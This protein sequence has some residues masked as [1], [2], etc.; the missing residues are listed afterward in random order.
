MPNGT[1]YVM[2][3]LASN[4]IT[5]PDAPI[6][7]NLGNTALPYEPYQGS[8]TQLPLPKTCYGGKVE[9]RHN[10]EF[11]KCIVLDGTEIWTEYTDE[12]WQGAGYHVYRFYAADALLV[13]PIVSNKYP[14]V[15]GLAASKEHSA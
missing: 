5:N 10:S 13:Q 14:Y 6:M 9:W 12:N 8:S 2:F 7:L 1:Y 11:D 4:R 3:T 15:G